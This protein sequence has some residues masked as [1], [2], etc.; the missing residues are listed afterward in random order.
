MKLI[1]IKNSWILLIYKLDGIIV[2]NK[3]MK[4]NIK[5]KLV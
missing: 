4:I 3:L 5:R 2:E 1:L